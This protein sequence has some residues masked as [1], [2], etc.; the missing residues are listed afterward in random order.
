MTFPCT[1]VP[2]TQRIKTALVIRARVE[3]TMDFR[4]LSRSSI[5]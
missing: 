1:R 2:K 5:Q 4:T 3:K